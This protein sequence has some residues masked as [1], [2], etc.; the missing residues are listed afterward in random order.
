MCIIMLPLASVLIP[1]LI[2]VTLEQ[3]IRAIHFGSEHFCCYFDPKVNDY[4]SLIKI[5]GIQDPYSKFIPYFNFTGGQEY[6]RSIWRKL[7][8]KLDD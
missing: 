3:I 7:K 5:H 4:S 8:G 2:K 1:H 6:R